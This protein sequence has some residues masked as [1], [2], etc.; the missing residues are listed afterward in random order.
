MKCGEDASS[1]SSAD[2]LFSL[3]LVGE[4]CEGWR[5]NF[6]EPF[7]KLGEGESVSVHPPVAIRRSCGQAAPLPLPFTAGGKWGREGARPPSPLPSPSRERGKSGFSPLRG[8][9][10]VERGAKDDGGLKFKDID[11]GGGGSVF[12]FVFGKA[13]GGW[14]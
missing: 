2:V 10:G 14:V 12:L 6:C 11:D 5:A 3:S 4:G 1:P 13:P 7:P 8:R 9:E